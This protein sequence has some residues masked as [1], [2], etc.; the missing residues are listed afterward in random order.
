LCTQ[1]YDIVENRD[2][3][4]RD[5]PDAVSAAAVGAWAASTPA[6]AIVFAGGNCAIQVVTSGMLCSD[7]DISSCR[8]DMMRSV[9]MSTGP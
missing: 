2:V 7:P 9:K 5:V 6:E 1:A 4:Y 8:R 3:W